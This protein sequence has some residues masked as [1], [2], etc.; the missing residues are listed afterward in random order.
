MYHMSILLAYVHKVAR[1][2]FKFEWFR[3]R[4][5]EKPESFAVQEVPSGRHG[6]NVRKYP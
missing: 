5:L 2:K 6:A 1:K 3:A 4:V